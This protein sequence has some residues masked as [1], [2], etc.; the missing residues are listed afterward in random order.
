V[1]P[2]C[3]RLLK[4]IR[5]TFLKCDP[6]GLQTHEDYTHTTKYH[7][8]GVNIKILVA[9]ANSYD[10]RRLAPGNY[11]GF[12]PFVRTRQESSPPTLREKRRRLVYCPNNDGPHNGDSLCTQADL[13]EFGPDSPGL[14]ALLR[15]KRRL[16]YRPIHR[17]AELIL[18]EQEKDQ[19]PHD[20]PP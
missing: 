12:P 15:R 1:N 3:I 19:P 20:K 4:D 17:L 6:N 5:E 9:K 7:T 13:E 18:A 16:V 11:G 8:M 10:R 14:K 2:D